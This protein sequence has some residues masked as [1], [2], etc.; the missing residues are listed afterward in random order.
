MLLKNRDMWEQGFLQLL[1]LWVNFC[2]VTSQKQLSRA[3]AYKQVKHL[4][5]ATIFRVKHFIWDSSTTSMSHTVPSC[6]MKSLCSCYNRKS[7]F[8]EMLYLIYLIRCKCSY[9]YHGFG[10]SELINIPVYFCVA[11]VVGQTNFLLS[12]MPQYF[13]IPSAP[14]ILADV[15]CF[16]P[17][18]LKQ[19]KFCMVFLK[20]LNTQDQLLEVVSVPYKCLSCILIATVLNIRAFFPSAFWKVDFFFDYSSVT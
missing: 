9:G 8:V 10:F 11:W 6:F 17:S 4:K 16:F 15:Q 1:T 3:L 20:L 12:M 14:C 7:Y 13:L 5:Y 18:E 19:L 2:P